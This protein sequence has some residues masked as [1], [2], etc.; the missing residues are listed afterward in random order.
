MMPN[1]ECKWTNEQ[2]DKCWLIM[3]SACETGLDQISTNW[4]DYAKREQILLAYLNSVGLGLG[5]VGLTKLGL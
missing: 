4:K 2:L 1:R 5:T 3:Y